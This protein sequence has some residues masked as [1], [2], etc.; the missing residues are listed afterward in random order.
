MVRANRFALW[1]PVPWFLFAYGLFYGFGPLSYTLA[2]EETVVYMDDLYPVGDHALLQTNFLNAIGLVA[3][4][5]GVWMFGAANPVVVATHRAPARRTSKLFALAFLIVGIPVKYLVLIPYNLGMYDFFVPALLKDLGNLTLAALTILV[6]LRTILSGTW[7]VLLCVLIVSEV[8]SAVAT[9]SKLMMLSVLMALMLGEYL[10]TRNIW[11]F[12]ITGMSVLLLYALVLTPLVTVL[13]TTVNPRGIQDTTQ[14]REATEAAGA[15]RETYADLK[16]NVQGWWSRLTYT[17]VQAFAMERY[18]A[19][20]PGDSFGLIAWA[21][22][23][24]VLYPDK[25]EMTPGYHFTAEVFGQR[26]ETSTGL[27]IF[28]EAY[29]NGGWLF[30][31]LVG[32]YV[33]IVFALV[34]NWSTRTVADGKWYFAPA[35]L[36]AVMIGLGVTDWMAATYVGGV[37]YLLLTIVVISVLA[38][39]IGRKEGRQLAKSGRFHRSGLLHQTDVQSPP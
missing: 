35:L 25:P 7:R 23:P 9:L 2:S 36:N 5:V 39:V 34:G 14:A 3:V 21:P 18:Q 6:A 37:L 26:L 30:V 16:P 32:L 28:G 15:I 13:R 24:R 8:V 1:S 27:G 19:G 33:G 12:F 20:L 38:N 10:R 4:A 11:W 31:C 22:V 17:N 29:W